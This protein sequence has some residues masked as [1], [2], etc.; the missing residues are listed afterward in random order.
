MSE[1]KPAIFQYPQTTFLFH[2]SILQQTTGCI[3]SH[4]TCCAH[5][6]VASFLYIRIVR[7][8]LVFWFLGNAF[9][10]KMLMIATG[11]ILEVSQGTDKLVL[12]DGLVLV[13]KKSDHI[14][15][16]I[17]TCDN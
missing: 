2:L 12:A 3:N 14:M 13:I 7:L 9:S 4:F 8:C 10:S 11:H 1:E 16:L 5:R 6:K 17:S 15:L